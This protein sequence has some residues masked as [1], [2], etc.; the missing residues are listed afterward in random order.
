MPKGFA[1]LPGLRVEVEEVI[2]MPHLD[3][4]EDRPHSFVY[5]LSIIN[6]SKTVVSIRGRKWI[7][8]DKK[9]EITI[10]EGSGV[11]GEN[12]VL[13]PGERF[14]YNSYHV[15][16]SDSEVTGTFFGLDPEGKG[17]RVS[18][19]AFSLVVPGGP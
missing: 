7:L 3:A 10:V 15:I 1:E 11:V 9:G 18:I 4:P 6:D 13:K 17:I 5:F 19:P 16:A 14:S 12:P 2:F 8:K